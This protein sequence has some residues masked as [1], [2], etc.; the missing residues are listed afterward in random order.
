MSAAPVTFSLDARVRFTLDPETMGKADEG[1]ARALVE[2]PE[3]VLDVIKEAL[4]RIVRSDLDD[5]LASDVT[6]TVSGT[7]LP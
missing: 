3:A 6:V 7:V 2:K 1:V 4:A 5:P